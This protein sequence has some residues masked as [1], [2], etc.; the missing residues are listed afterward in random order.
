[1]GFR[2]LIKFTSMDKGIISLVFYKCKGFIFFKYNI[3]RRIII[4]GLELML[5]GIVL[6]SYVACYIVCNIR[7]F[8]FLLSVC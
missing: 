7:L 6:L 3:D 5:Y 2:F 4:F 1:M 8:K